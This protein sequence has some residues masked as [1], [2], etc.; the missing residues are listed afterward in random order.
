[1]SALVGPAAYLVPQGDAR[2]LG[3]ALITVLVEEEVAQKL[4]QEGRQRVAAWSLP[5]F[6]A[7]LAQA[8]QDIINKGK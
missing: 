3:A 2:L 7:G 4:I 6:A 5:A 8:Y 1:M